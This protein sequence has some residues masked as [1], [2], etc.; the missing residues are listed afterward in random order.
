LGGA[1]DFEREGVATMAHVPKRATQHG[2]FL[3]GCELSPP[4]LKPGQTELH[5]QELYTTE[6]KPVQE[7]YLFQEQ[8]RDS[9]YTKSLARAT[10]PEDYED[11]TK[12]CRPPT[13]TAG[14]DTGGTEHWVSEYK[15]ALNQA[16][17][18]QAEFGRPYFPIEDFG[19][20]PAL[21]GRGNVNSTY[22][23]EFGK[24]RS[25][26]RDKI[27]L[28]LKRPMDA[29]TAKGTMHVPGYQGFIP[30]NT[31]SEEVAR[32]EKGD[33]CRSVD[34]TNIEQTYHNN[35]IGYS[36]HEPK[37]ALNDRGGRKPSSRTVYDHDYPDPQS[38]KLR[39]TQA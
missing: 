28:N 35:L 16:K 17:S 18:E 11:P 13:V 23:E 15:A 7:P 34:K 1:V 21:S 6:A 25:N 4:A 33:F 3:S 22:A 26:P 20:A 32:I 39:A 30:G 14:G 29:G 24:Y 8:F 9:H 37:S 38:H 10:L 12:P 31:F 2:I 36:G 19:E 5:R 27:G